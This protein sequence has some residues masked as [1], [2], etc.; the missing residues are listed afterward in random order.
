MNKPVFYWSTWA[1]FS[2]YLVIFAGAI[3]RMTG[4]GMGCPDW[5]KCF[6]YIIPPTDRSQLDWQPGKTYEKGNVIIMDNT[7]QVATLTFESGKSFDLQNWETYTKHDYTT[8][9]ATHTWVEFINR[10]LG[11][12]SGL[13]VL[14]LFFR[15]LWWIRKQHLLSLFSFFA[16]V[17]MGIQ[18]WLGK[19]VVDSNLL[20]SKISL[21]MSMALMIVGVLLFVRAKSHVKQIQQPSKT[22]LILIVGSF[23]L[24][25]IQFGLGVDVRQFIDF[26]IKK[27][28]YNSPQLWL[29]RPEISFYVHRS[30]SLVVVV[31]SIWIY[32]M[33]VREGIE[34]KYIKFI[35]GCIIAE[36][37][38]GILMYYIDFPWGTQPLHLLIAALLFSAQLY[39]LFR[40]KIKPYDLPI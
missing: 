21:H 18:A 9:N 10:L 24:T 30:L 36:I 35:F 2:V 27:I 3:V 7:L 32:K 4:S 39:W 20:P 33:V 16:V 40:I 11:A 31:L 15:S 28:G 12:I 19:T 22:L 6:G 23:T 5:P 14:V 34:K 17:G 25:L 8:F 38:L 1:L 13:I 29:D 26:Q 37:T